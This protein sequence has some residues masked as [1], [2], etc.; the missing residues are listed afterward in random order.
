MADP[1]RF[2]TAAV[3]A[4]QEPDPQ[5]GAV[6]TPVY[7]SSTFRQSAPGVAPT[8]YDY[9]RTDHPTRAALERNLAALEGA[10]HG[11][12]FA[13]GM[14]ATNTVL[15]TLSAGDHIVACRDLY[16]G[17][18]R[19]F[20]KVY[21][22][23]G[24]SFSFVRTDRLEE[25]EPAL[26]PT[27]RFLWLESPSNPQLTITDLAA[28][29][30]VAHR[31]GVKVVVDNTF[32]TPFLQRPL[33]LGCDVVVHSTTKYIGGHSDVL[34]GAIVTNDTELH[35]RMKFMQNAVGG[36]PGA[37]DCFLVLRGTKTL[38]VRM[39]RHCANAQRLF[40]F[41]CGHRDVVHVHY[42]GDPAFPNHAIA[43]KQ[44]K[45]FG[46]MVSVE[47]SGGVE[48]N[49]R[50]CSMT[51]LFTLAVSLGGVES[52]ISQPISMT[53]AAVPA[54]ERAKSGLPDSLVRLSAGIE[55]ADDLIAD[56]QQAIDRSR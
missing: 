26:R 28:A 36:V 18:H 29:S 31:R 11:L 30:A 13:S 33:E 16:G 14:A 22:K 40:E 50:F 3:H 1:M 5:T 46:G 10:R 35:E 49:R 47:L 44:M 48:R 23:L 43:R 56:L 25:I 12:C 37:L 7:L 55:D 51:R 54:E 45:D 27:T 34:G 6:M 15:A 24:I 20:T 21:E 8:G 19:I 41:L 42:P 52:L 17:S 2:A 9:A 39:E 4:G 32:A 53:H 38:H